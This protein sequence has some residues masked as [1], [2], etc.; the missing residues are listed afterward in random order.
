MKLVTDSPREPTAA[1]DPHGPGSVGRFC[2][3]CPNG[4]ALPS[5]LTRRPGRDGAP[6]FST[7]GTVNT[8]TCQRCHAPADHGRDFTAMHGELA[9]HGR[10][11]ACAGCHRQDW[12][13][14]DRQLQS[15]VLAAERALKANP[16]DGQ[17][18][19][20]VGPNNFCVYCHRMDAKW[21]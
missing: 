21:R 15:A 12:G 5:Q 6:V 2:A 11:T 20:S 13:A 14:G 3:S 8:G 4:G 16:D 1:L 9:E 10:A 18:A 19:L 7:A 17:A